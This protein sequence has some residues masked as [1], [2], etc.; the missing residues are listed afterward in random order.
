MK[1]EELKMKIITNIIAV[2]GFLLL[3]RAGRAQD[4][5]EL[6][7]P[8]DSC[9]KI[10]MGFYSLPKTAVTGSVTTG[11]GKSLV[12]PVSNVSLSLAGK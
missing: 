10:D 7:L 9:E 12:R 5:S 11:Q 1:K 2:C 4:V 3:C 6:S 8:A